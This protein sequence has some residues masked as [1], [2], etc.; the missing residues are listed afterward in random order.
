MTEQELLDMIISERISELL[1]AQQK[2]EEEKQKELRLISQAENL[3][4]NLPK[5]DC[6]IL[7]QYIDHTTG[8]LAFEAAFLY[9]QGFIDGVRVLNS[10]R[11]L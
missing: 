1:A 8:Q 4:K 2:S 7:S 10:L 6:Q 9:R 11:T 3:I 5:A